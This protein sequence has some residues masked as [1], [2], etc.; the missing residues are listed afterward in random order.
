MYC[1]WSVSEKLKKGTAGEQGQWGTHYVTGLPS[2]TLS[3]CLWDTGTE[4]TDEQGVTLNKWKHWFPI[5]YSLIKKVMSQLI[6]GTMLKQTNKSF[7]PYCWNLTWVGPLFSHHK[8]ADHLRTGQLKEVESTKGQRPDTNDIIRCPGIGHLRWRYFSQPIN[9]L[10]VLFGFSKMM[11]GGKERWN[12]NS[13]EKG[14]VGFHRKCPPDDRN[15]RKSR[16]GGQNGNNRD[17]VAR[18]PAHTSPSKEDLLLATQRAAVW[19]VTQWSPNFTT[20]S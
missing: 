19:K 2:V 5:G 7:L 13:S 10:C 18:C 3:I 12:Q 8:E 6:W 16:W 11:M 4:T 1:G 20:R 14:E 15:H 9:P 17:Q